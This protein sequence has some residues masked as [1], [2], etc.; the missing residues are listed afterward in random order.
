M[1]TTWPMLEVLHGVLQ[2]RHI[3][4]KEETRLFKLENPNHLPTNKQIPYFHP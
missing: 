3:E 4:A 2:A 1:P